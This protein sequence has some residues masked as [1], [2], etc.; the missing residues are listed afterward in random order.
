MKVISGKPVKI[1]IV[2]TVE[3]TVEIEDNSILMPKRTIKE[4]WTLDNQYIGRLDPL[5]DY[6]AI[7]E[8]IILSAS[9]T[10]NSQEIK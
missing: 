8:S 1:Q 9:E 4:F 6:L 3:I 5:D 7:E 10:F 2:P